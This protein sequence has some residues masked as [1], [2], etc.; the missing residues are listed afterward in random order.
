VLLLLHVPNT[1]GDESTI[2]LMA[3]HIAQGRHFPA[4][5]YGDDYMGAFEA[6]LAAPVVGLFGPSVLA[7][8]LPM[9]L[10][11]YV[12]F[13]WLMY[14]LTARLYTRWFAVLIAGLMALGSDHIISM[15][16]RASGGYPELSAAGALLILLAVELAAGDASQ[17][18]R[19][20]LTFG[21]WGV[22]AG[23]VLW[24]NWLPLP[25][26]AVAAA[27]LLWT[28]RRELLGRAG[29]MLAAGVAV[30]ATPMIVHLLHAA[31]GH[32]V[33]SQV[34]A[35]SKGSTPVG[36]G[37]RLY[38]GVLVGLPFSSG[39]CH[40]DRCDPWQMSWAPIYLALL[41]MAAGLAVAGLIRTRPGAAGPGNP[42]ETQ[43]RHAGRLALAVAAALG[44]FL[45]VRSATA[46]VEP[47][48][49]A[50]YLHALPIS[51]P[52][53]LWPLWTAARRWPVLRGFRTERATPRR[54]VRAGAIGSVGMLACFAATMLV[55]TV[56]AVLN[57]P[58][59]SAPDHRVRALITTLDR[60][61]ATRVYSDYPTCNRLS[62]LTGER[63]VC[64][65]IH[66]DLGRGKDRYQ[67]YR[68]AVDADARPTY[69]IPAD[70]PIRR[71]FEDELARED[72]TADAREAAGYRIYRPETRPAVPRR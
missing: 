1:D 43:I 19:R 38:G 26:L 15:Q 11:L 58:R 49:N 65:V 12:A 40:P 71:A 68:E 67:P 35:L 59:A 18:W 70:S 5:F 23:F 30:G 25:Y 16:L 9:V 41:A 57:V 72:I 37:D 69:A 10:A 28:C 55:A 36:P 31:P 42:S 47:M 64:A 63:M 39:L 60:L 7:L 24:D 8:R 33:L 14:R 3:L 6:Y 20:L 32:N 34:L 54:L 48:S 17:G 13:G 21:G 61:G 4:Y 50:R 46:G 51:L 27:L 62:Y 44:L 45:Y 52:A 56:L 66:N 22:A 29:A 53:A 2:G